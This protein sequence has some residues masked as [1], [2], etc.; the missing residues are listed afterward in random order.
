M[1]HCSERFAQRAIASG[2]SKTSRTGTVCGPALPHSRFSQRIASVQGHA[3][4]DCAH[5]RAA[6]GLFKTRRSVGGCKEMEQRTGSPSAHCPISCRTGGPPKSGSPYRSASL[7]FDWL[8]ALIP[9]REGYRPSTTSIHLSSASNTT[10][11]NR[12]CLSSEH[13]TITMAP[14]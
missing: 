13:V 2:S 14:I 9:C 4:H 6:P 12:E 5:A 11:D 1:F 8:R 3:R 7:P 10:E